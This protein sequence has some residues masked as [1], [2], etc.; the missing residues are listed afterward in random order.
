MELK[1]AQSFGAKNATEE[2]I[3]TAFADDSRRGEFVIIEES[4]H[5]FMQ[6]AGELDGPYSLEYREAEHQYYCDK[7][8]SKA[9]VEAAFLKYL[10][11][12]HSYRSDFGWKKLD[13]SAKPWWK[14]W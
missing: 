6:A 7:K 2:D 5:A 11:H 12:D 10:R 14:I 4:D 8:V 1:T 3:R 13:I 9:E